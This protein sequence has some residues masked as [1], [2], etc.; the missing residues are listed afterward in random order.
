MRG[1][2]A[3]MSPEQVLGTQP[4]DGRSDIYALGCL[5]YWL[6]T[7]QMVFTGRTAMETITQHTHSAPVP[8][9][10]RTELEIPEAFDRVVLGCLEKRPDRRPATVAVLA[11]QL[12]PS[13]PAGRGHQTSRR[14]GGTPTIREHPPMT[15]PPNADKV[16]TEEDVETRGARTIR[17]EPTE[18]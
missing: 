12:R 5:A 7:R 14:R 13:I 2:P 3:F 18:R 9:S 11:Q 16:L 1:T 15:V 10:R 6:V 8:P 4:V 17:G